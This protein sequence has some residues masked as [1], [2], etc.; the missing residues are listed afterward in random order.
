M[1]VGWDLFNS[2]RHRDA[3]SDTPTILATGLTYKDQ[4]AP[5]Y[6]HQS[7]RACHITNKQAYYSKSN[8]IYFFRI[9]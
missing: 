9:K 5:V 6:L 2:H 1:T 7:H 3:H 4:Y 8:I